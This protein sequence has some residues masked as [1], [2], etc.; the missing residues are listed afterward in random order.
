MTL[1]AGAVIVVAWVVAVVVWLIG[2][3]MNKATVRRQ[4]LGSRLVEM[5]PLVLGV[6]LLRG[7]PYLFR[8]LAVRFL[9]DTAAWRILGAALTVIG[10]VVA[11]WA[12]FYLGK[13]W[14]ATVTVKEKHELIQSGPYSLVRHPIY[15]GFLLAILGTVIYG[16][17]GR[18]L[19]ALA[20]I[21]VTWKIK[22]IHEEAF[23]VSE[24]GEHYVEY[25]QRVKAL[26][27][28]IW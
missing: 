13:N 17:E 19:I 2:S 8:T 28:F 4:S 26:I 11:I 25:R 21:L 24:F 18:G 1:G 3:V 10:V 20:L 6:I 15:S 5:A 14:S 12:R 9:P 16:G 22:S 27:P 23:M 7:D